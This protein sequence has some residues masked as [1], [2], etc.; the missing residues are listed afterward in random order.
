MQ[1]AACRDSLVIACAAIAC[2]QAAHLDAHGGADLLL[3]HAALDEALVDLHEGMQH[4]VSSRQMLEE[5][6]P[7]C[8]LL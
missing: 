3:Q 2:K 7:A 4:A 5:S 6:L 1:D 8:M